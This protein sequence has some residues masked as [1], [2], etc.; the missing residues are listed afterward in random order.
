[1]SM[2]RANAVSFVLVQ[3][4]RRSD[5][6]AR[7]LRVLIALT[8]PHDYFTLT[9][10]TIPKTYYPGCFTPLRDIHLQEVSTTTNPEHAPTIPF[11]NVA[12]YLVHRLL[13]EEIFCTH[14]PDQVEVF[15]DD[16]LLLADSPRA[17]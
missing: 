2:P 6:L 5:S 3:S 17:S 14:P 7:V 13:E 4:D 12:V 9:F 16:V 11:F 8:I 1:M 15:I 10:I